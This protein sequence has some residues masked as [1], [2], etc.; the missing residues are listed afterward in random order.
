MEEN[1]FDMKSFLFIK[2]RISN[3]K[4]EKTARFS[5]DGKLKMLNY[6]IGQIKSF[7]GR[8]TKSELSG[9]IYFQTGLGQRISLSIISWDNLFGEESGTVCPCDLKAR[10]MEMA[11]LVD[12]LPLRVYYP[13]HPIFGSLSRN[14]WGKLIFRFLDHNLRQ[15]N[16]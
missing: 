7:L 13:R 12:E 9:P 1:I 11:G 10:Q 4:L 14:E 16:A 6:C 2:E 15:F 5:S 3:F 8:E